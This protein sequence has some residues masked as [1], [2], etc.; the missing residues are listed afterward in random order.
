M[1]CNFQTAVI[2]LEPKKATERPPIQQVVSH[3]H[4]YLRA[5][6][7]K[8]DVGEQRDA[9]NWEQPAQEGHHKHHSQT[10][11]VTNNC[12]YT[13]HTE[14]IGSHS[15]YIHTFTFF[16]HTFGRDEMRYGHVAKI[17]RNTETNC[18]CNLGIAYILKFLNSQD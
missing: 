18:T 16:L 3:D 10:Y 12:V 13:V 9:K 5:S 1:S 7:Q 15:P 2:P 17:K 6:P 14:E 4:G 8:G 11:Q